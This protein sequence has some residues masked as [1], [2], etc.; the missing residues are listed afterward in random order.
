MD[1]V[2]DTFSKSDILSYCQHDLETAS[3][4]LQQWESEGKLEILKPLDQAGD[5]EPVVKMKTYI[6]GKSP[7]PNW[8]PKD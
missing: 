7:W 3:E 4:C 2:L 5:D 1:S 6:E 8:P